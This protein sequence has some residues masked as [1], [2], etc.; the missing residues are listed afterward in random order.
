MLIPTTYKN[1]SQKKYVDIIQ[2][3]KLPLIPVK[4]KSG[5]LHLFLFLKDWASVQDV[6]KKI[7]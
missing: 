3:Y 6:R 1:Y 2:E 7:G 4:S 5:G